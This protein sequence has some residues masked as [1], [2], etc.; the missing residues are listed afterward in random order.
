MYC[1]HFSYYYFIIITDF[2][3]WLAGLG[4]SDSEVL[5]METVQQFFTDSE[6]SLYL[7][8]DQCKLH[9]AS[10][11]NGKAVKYSIGASP[12]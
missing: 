4:L 8:R 12:A 1:L 7:V 9:S 11:N 3:N 5:P 10:W 6:I 2:G